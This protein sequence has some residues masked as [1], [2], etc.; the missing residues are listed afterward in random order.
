MLMIIPY[1]ILIP[2]IGI[3][4]YWTIDKLLFLNP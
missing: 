1:K 3:F 2:R 4:A